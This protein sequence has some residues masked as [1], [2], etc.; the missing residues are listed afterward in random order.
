VIQTLSSVLLIM[1]ITVVLQCQFYDTETIP[2][3]NKDARDRTMISASLA[4]IK[5]TG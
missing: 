4:A 1:T 3:S 2:N 5:G